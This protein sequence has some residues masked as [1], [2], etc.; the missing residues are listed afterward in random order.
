MN[1]IAAIAE[2][3]SN[4]TSA[5]N[6]PDM[7][8]NVRE[9][10]GIDSE[11]EVPAFSVRT[12]HVPEPDSAYQFDRETTLAI[13]AGFTFNRRVMIQGYHG[14]GNPRQSGFAHLPD[15]PDRQGRHRPERRQTG[16]RIPRR[17]PAL[18]AAAP[19]RPGVRRI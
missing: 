17:H 7:K 13:L 8:L 4:P 5:I 6:T 9:V 18:G 12:E 11:L 1:N 14:T 16:H 15:R 19:L 2:A 3:R 10:F